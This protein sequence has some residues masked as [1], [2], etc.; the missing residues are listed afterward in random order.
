M[1]IQSFTKSRCPEL[2]DFLEHCCTVQLNFD[3]DCPNQ[4]SAFNHIHLWSLEWWADHHA[5][6]D[7]DY[8][9][10]FCK[11][12]FERWRQ[13][14][15]GLPP[16]REKGYRFYLYEDLAP[17]VSV[18]AETP[19]GFAYDESGA[20][21][22]KHTRDIMSL[23]VNKS[24]QNNFSNAPWDVSQNKLLNTVDNHKGSISK[25]TAE[26]LGIGVG[27]LR[28]LIEQMGLEDEVNSL[29]KRYGRRPAKFR[30]PYELPFRYKIYEL[31]LSAGYR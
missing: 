12:I 25:P 14:L 5:W 28:I 15:K 30:D 18:V 7:L 16:Y 19:S 23:Y 6:I 17:T 8:R 9:V 4:H 2:A 29:R 27:K 26:A 21:F 13:R 31:R 24:W 22:V 3:G 20:T 1:S 10:E 11:H